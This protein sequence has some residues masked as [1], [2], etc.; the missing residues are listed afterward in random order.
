MVPGS[1]DN[2]D[3]WLTLT[4]SSTQEKLMLMFSYN[5][6]E[7]SQTYFIENQCQIGIEKLKKGILTEYKGTMKN[8]GEHDVIKEFFYVS[9]K[10]KTKQIVNIAS[11][12][13][14]YPEAIQEKYLRYVD[15]YRRNGT[16]NFYAFLNYHA[17]NVDDVTLESLRFELWV[18]EKNAFQGDAIAGIRIWQFDII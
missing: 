1:H 15:T 6:E 10:N 3:N 4:S 5:Y 7:R 11:R 16:D 9:L 8:C 14:E 12:Y 2:F 18:S 13:P 17:M